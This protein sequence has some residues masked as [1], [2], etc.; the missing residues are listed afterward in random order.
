M[1]D[2][3]RN[4]GSGLLQPRS[5]IG[6]AMATLLAALLLASCS[7]SGGRPSGSR[8]ATQVES[9]VVGTWQ[10]TVSKDDLKG[11]GISDPGTL[12]ENAGRFTRSFLADG[13]WTS[14]QE[15]LD[16]SPIHNPAWRGTYTV[17]GDEIRVQIEFPTEYQ[18]DLERYRWTVGGG[19]LQLTMIEP[20]DDP[21]ARLL[22]EA[23]PWT[24][25]TP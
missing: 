17:E 21:I 19:E 4:R 7:A 16:S 8:S 11:I 15:S 20:T 1:R 25:T 6:L 22:T 2:Q 9:P 10:M 23:H 18:G 12:N 3:L 5:S 14:A 24:R 13:T